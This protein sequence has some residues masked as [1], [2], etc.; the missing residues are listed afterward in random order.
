MNGSFENNT[1]GGVD[2]INLSNAVF[3]GYMPN[4]NSWGT[5]PNLD[6]IQSGTWGGGGAQHCKWYVALTGSGTDAMNMQLSAPLVTGNTY[7]ISFYDRKDGAWPG[8]PIQIG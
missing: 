2:R 4:T 6:I 7:T 8:F 3:N 5:T 1:A